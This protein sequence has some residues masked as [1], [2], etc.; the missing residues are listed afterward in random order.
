[1]RPK[2]ALPIYGAKVL[3]LVLLVCLPLGAKA[4]SKVT[5]LW[6]T[7]VLPGV[8]QGSGDAQSG[9]S[10][11]WWYSEL[12]NKYYLFLPAAANLSDLRVWFKSA[13]EA[14][15]IEGRAV[16]NGDP[17]GFLTPGQDVAVVAGRTKYKVAVMQSATVPAMFITTDSG[18]LTYI[19]KRKSNEEPGTLIMRSADG[20][21]E[22]DGKLS[23]VKGRGSASF[24]NPKKSYQIKL[25]RSSDL[26]GM[27]KGRGNSTFQLEKK[28]YQIKLD[29]SADLCGLGK[30]KTWILLAEYRD[31]SLLRN[32]VVFAMAEAVGLAY[33]S[34]AQF[35]DVYINNDYYGAYLLCEKVEVG[36]A[37]VDIAD[38]E[39]ATELLN[40][41]PLDSYKK[42]G[43]RKTSKNTG[44]GYEIPN[45][46][47]DITGGYLV[48]LEKPLF[49]P[50]DPSG[51]TT[52]RG[53][54]VIVKEP[55]NVS[56]AQV[57][58]IRA[59]FQGFENAIFAK[60][61]IDPDSGKHYSEFVDM[62]SLVKKYLIEEITKNYDGNTS[63][64]FFYK[65]ADSQS[66]IAFAGPVWDYDI[67]LG[68][69]ST[70]KSDFYALPES[71]SICTETVR[72]YYWL[73]A[74]YRQPD[75]KAAVEKAYRDDFLPVIAVLLGQTDER[76]GDLRS[77]DEYAS[78]ISAC[79][80]M[81]FV[82][83]PIF[84]LS[85]RLVKTGGNYQENIGHLKNYIGQ[86]IAFLS[87]SWLAD[88]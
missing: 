71:F 14:I 56:R 72:D 37:R 9:P 45:N 80:N 81:N 4:A 85:Y 28:P 88:P 41:K 53:Q 66:K 38:L 19:H 22:Y 23:Q 35:T 86:R 33:T 42:F 58:Y 43:K 13:E 10:V 48:E 7:G 61:G 63:S 24:A 25:N 1:M 68:N 6:V 11:H 67:A 78:E 21:L 26:C 2:P 64:R 36:S 54:P 83:W 55:K 57:D 44:K 5:D 16:K 79:A 27:G 12:A 30:A 40:E 39:G 59:F 15:T 17:A 74:L 46:P 76:P 20:S 60:D 18:S 50:S 82:R 32:R 69:Y 65:P 52:K 87:G 3:L 73:P 29:R 34:K 62:D 84:N 51:F 47:Q 75:F 49:Y 77:I 70:A 8:T 31:N